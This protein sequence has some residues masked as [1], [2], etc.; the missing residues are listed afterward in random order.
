MAFLAGAKYRKTEKSE[1]MGVTTVFSAAGV[2]KQKFL[3]HTSN[4][5]GCVKEGS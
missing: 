4:M 2:D 1:M 3:D 5:S